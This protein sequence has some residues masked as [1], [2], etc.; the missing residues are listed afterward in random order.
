M[1]KLGAKIISPSRRA[2]EG[3]IT[4]IA[5]VA[6]VIKTHFVP[7]YKH[8]MP[9]LKQTVLTAQ[10][11]D[12]RALRGKAFECMSLLG[13]AVGRDLFR[14]DAHE[15]M[16]AMMEIAS[17]GLAADDPQRTYIYEASERICRDLR[18][19][20]M[21]YLPYLL[22]GIYTMLQSQPNE[23]LDPDGEEEEDMSVVLLQDGKAVGLK[24]IQIE[25]MKSAVHM[26]GVFLDSLGGHYFDHLQET[27]RCLSPIV[28][29]RFSD[30]VKK[31]A[32]ITWQELLEAA[33][34]GLAQRQLSDTSLVGDLLRHFVK[35]ALEGMETEEDL[36]LLTL[37]AGG[38]ADCIRSAGPG[39]MSLDEVQAVCIAVKG[40]I[41]TSIERQQPPLDM[42]EL[43][44]DEEA[45]AEQWSAAHQN[46][47]MRYA[48]L[49]GI[50]METYKAPFLQVGTSLFATVLQ[51][52]LR[53]GS[54][55]SDHYL[56]LYLL[57]VS[58]EKL[59]TE[60]SAFSVAYLKPML[61]SL[62]H[63]DGQIRSAAAYGVLFAARL[64]DFGG[65]APHAAQCLDQAISHP[66]AW[67]GTSNID[68]TELAVAA[69]GS[70]CRHQA[71]SINID[72]YLPQF[73]HGL[74]IKHDLD[75]AGPTHEL[76]MSFVKDGHP[77]FQQQ[78]SKI[79]SI[80]L[81]V[82]DREYSTTQLDG[83]IRRM[84]R[85]L[86]QERIQQMRPPLS[87]KQKQRMKK[88]IRDAK[89]S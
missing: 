74:P 38:L 54:N 31:E 76:L 7:Y 66:A 9:V 29:F 14:Q 60:G 16:Q 27:A 46:L 55:L 58:F 4:A 39:V 15:A 25:D 41:D 17:Q 22:P 33:K 24:T 23:L 56:G 67:R 44:D 6:A 68:C 59:G 65:F 21:P 1:E 85:E 70:L 12:E 69:L 84:F 62:Q 72:K 88:I 87:E 49:I 45:E 2:K 10:K 64:A 52:C 86:P 19:D 11:L 51:H 50:I 43:N 3:S 32:I 57:G 34:K 80:F 28:N 18:E 63:E 82:Y 30:D 5:V 78:A 8:V 75:Q 48:D 13:H 40:L 81:D 35:G 77:V 20:F 42:Q 83:D 73:I 89:S 36:E 53:E 79:C 26:L 37:Q 47:R 71:S 61:V